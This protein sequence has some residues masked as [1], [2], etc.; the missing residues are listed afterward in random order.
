MHVRMYVHMY[1]CIYV[2]IYINT[3]IHVFAQMHKRT[4]TSNVQINLAKL[5]YLRDKQAGQEST[6]QLV[7]IHVHT[8]IYIYI[9]MYM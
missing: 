4:N 8:Y 3:S 7:Y 5:G 9:Y 2:R 1:L 6:G